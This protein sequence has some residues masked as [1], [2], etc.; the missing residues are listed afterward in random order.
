MAKA[1]SSMVLVAK[2]NS[3][4]W[5][6]LLIPV[7]SVLSAAATDPVGYSPPIPIPTD[8]LNPMQDTMDR[9]VR[10][11]EAK[12]SPIKKRYA[13]KA[14]TVPCTPGPLDAAHRAEKMN[15]MR[16]HAS[17]PNLRP[18][19]SETQPKPTCQLACLAGSKFH[20][21]LLRRAPHVVQRCTC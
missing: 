7:F 15:T 10:R 8:Q 6:R 3:F 5:L 9:S 13:I 11:S 19:L 20:P 12:G 21:S 1:K 4:C 2:T 17:M 16:V 18:I 14:L